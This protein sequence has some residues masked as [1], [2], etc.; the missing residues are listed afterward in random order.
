[1]G[2]S[3]A[4][5]SYLLVHNRYGI[6]HL[7]AIGAES[8]AGMIRLIEIKH[9]ESRPLAL[10]H[11]EICFNSIYPSAVLDKRLVAVIFPIRWVLTLDIDV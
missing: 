3:F 1:M 8:V 2:D 7:V 10:R 4:K 5:S 9:D 6:S 11:I